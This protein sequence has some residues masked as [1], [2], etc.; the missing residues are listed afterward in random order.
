MI[1]STHSRE[2]LSQFSIEPISSI[3]DGLNKLPRPEFYNI[4]INAEN[5]LSNFFLY[6]SYPGGSNLLRSAIR[7]YERCLTGKRDSECGE[8]ANDI[9]ITAGATSGI[10]YYFNYMRNKKALFLGYHY[11]HFKV[12]A[13]ENNVY[14]E[15]ITSKYPNRIAPTIDEVEKIISHFDFITITLPFNP[16]GEMYSREEIERLLNLCVSNNVQVLIDKCQWDEIMISRRQDYYSLGQVILS[17]KAQRITTIITSFSKTRSIP[18]ARLGYA[19]GPHSTIEHMIYMNNL[20]LW[21]PCTFLLFPVIVDFIAQL[22]YLTEE[23]IIRMEDNF[24]LKFRHYIMMSYQ[25]KECIKYVLSCIAPQSIANFK[26]QL[27][28]RLCPVPG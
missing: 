2:Y 5:Q 23:M 24:Y 10:F 12:A 27:L 17:Q 6:Y 15:V 13:Q 14:Y 25:S 8:Y 22:Q 9:C 3:S 20:I 11:V 1:N 7:T 26:L 28:S 16:S 4:F 19:F 21:H 18:G